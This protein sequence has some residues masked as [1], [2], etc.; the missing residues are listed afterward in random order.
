V[1]WLSPD[2]W[3]EPTLVRVRPDG[4]AMLNG[5][6]IQGE[7]YTKDLREQTGYPF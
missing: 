5:V 2:G 1:L 4:R 6:E 7:D 3:V